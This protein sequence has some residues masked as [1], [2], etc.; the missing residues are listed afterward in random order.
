MK[1]VINFLRERIVLIIFSFLF[2]VLAVGGMQLLNEEMG[3]SPYPTN[4]IWL[5]KTNDKKLDN[6]EVFYKKMEEIAKN[7]KINIIKNVIDDKGR[8]LGYVFGEEKQAFS[9][10]EIYTRDKILLKTT[11]SQ[12]SYYINGNVSEK[13]LKEIERL[14]VEVAIF[15][16]P[17][18]MVA[19]SFLTGESIYS[20][21]FFVMLLMFFVVAYALLVGRMKETIIERSF[22]IFH[23]KNF[24]R[25]LKT[26]AVTLSSLSI[27]G[28]IFSYFFGYF[29][30]VKITAYAITILMFAILLLLILA[31]AHFIFGLQVMFSKIAD[32]QKNKISGKSIQIVW[33]AIIAISTFIVTL[34][35]A[36]IAK[37]YPKYLAQKHL[38]KEWEMAKDYSCVMWGDLGENSGT[39]EEQKANLSSQMNFAKSFSIDEVIISKITHDHAS[40]FGEVSVWNPETEEAKLVSVDKKLAQVIYTINPKVLELNKK[41]YPNNQYQFDKEKIVNILIPEKYRDRTEEI[42]LIVQDSLD[43]MVD[44]KDIAV[45]FIPNNQTFFLFMMGNENLISLPDSDKTD[46]ILVS[47]DWSK[48]PQNDHTNFVIENFT[49]DALYYAKGLQEK[50]KKHNVL[51]NVH[52]FVN[53]KSYLDEMSEYLNRQFISGIALLVVMFVF[54]LLV[55]YDFLKMQLQFYSKQ[56]IIRTIIGKNFHWTILRFQMILPILLV[57]VEMFSLFFTQTFSLALLFIALYLGAIALIYLLAFRG[58]RK[59]KHGIL[60]GATDII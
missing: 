25:F 41:I 26:L 57:L 37:N 24:T 35:T 44:K 50:A 20:L 19:A 45:Q 29:G 2:C 49:F 39:P 27:F 28:F 38:T 15:E 21:S 17:A 12:G 52:H 36:T 42:D 13:A 31:L 40:N 51:D 33:L 16:T 56:I 22:G 54:Q 30:S 10:P 43:Y 6:P 7:E 23:K 46:S 58:L 60:K 55:I 59:N 11:T 8:N 48:L 14:N 5:V 1:K 4:Q 18:W 53:V 9:S 3:F 32:V 34:E 47:F